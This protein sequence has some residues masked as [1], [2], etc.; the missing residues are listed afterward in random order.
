MVIQP[1]GDLLDNGTELGIPV[2]VDLAEFGGTQ[3]DLREQAV[4]GALERL[5]LDVFEALLLRVQ[6]LRVLGAGQV[7]DAVPEMQTQSIAV[8]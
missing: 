1:F 3:V 5:F 2:G 4:K 6:Q 8:F 7:G